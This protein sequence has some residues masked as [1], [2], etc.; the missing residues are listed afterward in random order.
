MKTAGVSPLF[1]GEG[2]EG[3]LL[4]GLREGREGAFEALYHQYC[5]RV[6][7]LALRFLHDDEQARNALQETFLR[8]FR[9]VHTFRGDSGLGTWIYRIAT[10]ICLNEIRRPEHSRLRRLGDEEEMVE[11]DASV[12][13]QA[14]R[15][16]LMERVSEIVSRLEPKKRITFLMF[17][18]EDLTADE[19]AEVLGEGRGKVLKR[20]QRTRAE[21]VEM[22]AE[23][24][25]T[26]KKPE[27]KAEGS[28]T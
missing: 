25:L 10:N 7:R 5:G 19:I 14:S 11:Q 13:E 1:K 12:D 17:Y 16:E 23:A 21:V 20:L 24:G 15:R 3:A 22:A 27:T 6:H 9:K 26:G 4:E 28:P 2:A 8:V 18:V